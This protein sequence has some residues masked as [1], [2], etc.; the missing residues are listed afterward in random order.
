MKQ[1]DLM[2]S[3]IKQVS[4]DEPEST[5]LSINNVSAESVSTQPENSQ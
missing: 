5:Q 2:E 1:L 3:T 4:A